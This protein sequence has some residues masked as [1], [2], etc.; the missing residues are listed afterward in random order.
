MN[1]Y[2]DT[3]EP[4]CINIYRCEKYLNGRWCPTGRYRLKRYIKNSLGR[5]ST[6]NRTFNSLSAAIIASEKTTTGKTGKTT[7]SASA[8]LFHEAFASFLSEKQRR[9]T[10]STI[11]QYEKLSAH[12]EFFRGLKISEI[13]S[14]TIDTWCSLL[15]DENY[16]SSKS[17]IN[18][19][20]EYTA[21]ATFFNWYRDFVDEFYHVPVLKRHR[22]RLCFRSKESRDEEIKFLTDIERARFLE[23]LGLRYPHYYHLAVVQLETGLRIGEILALRW[24]DIRLSSSFETGAIHVRRHVVW[25][26]GSKNKG[27]SIKRGTKNGK[28]R[29]VYLSEDAEKSIRETQQQ[30]SKFNLVFGREDFFLSYRSVENAYN[31]SFQHSGLNHRGTHVPRHSFA[32]SFLKE[33]KDIHSLQRLMGHKKLETTLRYAKYS[34]DTVEQA[35]QSFRRRNLRLVPPKIP[36]EIVG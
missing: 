9:C 23:E 19:Q 3:K 13:T 4:N 14:K 30:R 35:F 12:F 1:K 27:A 5:K 10:E 31:R 11:E 7:R 18:W 28:D 17:R 26:R 15:L 32:V 2:R 36:T 34:D 29:I 21:I 25:P 20:K 22:E 33:T 24:T 16:K 8:D 6:E